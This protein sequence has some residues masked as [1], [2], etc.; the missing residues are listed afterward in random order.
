MAG[1]NDVFTVF[2]VIA[3]TGGATSG[4]LYW[5]L[6]QSVFEEFS[7]VASPVFGKKTAKRKVTIKE[8]LLKLSSDDKA[9]FL[10]VF[11]ELKHTYFCKLQSQPLPFQ[12]PLAHKEWLLILKNPVSYISKANRLQ[13][14]FI[15]YLTETLQDDL[16]LHQQLA[17][18]ILTTSKS[19]N[20]T[21]DDYE[22]QLLILKRT[23]FWQLALELCLVTLT[24]PPQEQAWYGIKATQQATALKT[25]PRVAEAL[26]SVEGYW[27]V[28][29]VGKPRLH[30][31]LTQ[32]FQE[33][34]FA[35]R[36]HYQT[37][38]PLFPADSDTL[39][40]YALNT[41]SFI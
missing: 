3:G 23:V 19:S 24:L 2:L 22:L 35:K 28:L 34:D 41:P 4:A 21:G 38:A 37:F 33:N 15:A 10:L 8:K 5:L 26:S 17:R 20:A 36:Y 12:F 14:Q 1:V 6:N 40:R 29:E 39:I 25:K 7:A 13:Q 30:K 32:H 27:Q 16:D 18:Q 31:M 11:S 9:A